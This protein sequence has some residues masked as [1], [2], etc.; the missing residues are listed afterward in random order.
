M[1]P[2]APITEM[3]WSADADAYLQ[4]IELLSC[5]PHLIEPVSLATA[6]VQDMEQLRFLEEGGREYPRG[7]CDALALRSIDRLLDQ[8]GDGER[9]VL[10]PLLEQLRDAHEGRHSPNAVVE[11]GYQIARANR[12]RNRVR[13][14]VAL[15][16]N[17][18]E[19]LDERW[20]VWWQL[21]HAFAE[22]APDIAAQFAWEHAWQ[23]ALANG[24]SRYDVRQSARRA[25]DHARE[26]AADVEVSQWNRDIWLLAPPIIRTLLH[27][28]V[29][30]L[31]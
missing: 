3:L 21:P 10:F 15:M 25:R 16:L 12:D 5:H 31:Q 6:E 27:D 29:L 24:R 17:T 9:A 8:M 2:L 28:A 18:L 13:R 26:Q 11:H 7:L 22:L 1:I 30:V 14:M 19:P 23:Q 20:D 4:A